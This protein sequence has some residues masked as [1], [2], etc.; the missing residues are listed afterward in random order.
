MN[1]MEPIV[2]FI[3]GAFC[4]IAGIYIFVGVYRDWHKKKAKKNNNE[5]IP[6]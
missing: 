4:L 5:K 1:S 6:E 3:I 2:F